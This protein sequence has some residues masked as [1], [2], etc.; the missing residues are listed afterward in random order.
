MTKKHKVH[1]LTDGTLITT[2]EL[3][4]KLNCSY[5]TAHHRLQRTLDPEELF[6]KIRTTKLKHP[7]KKYTLDDG[8]RRTVE[9]ILK[10]MGE[11]K[12]KSPTIIARLGI[13]RDPVDILKPIGKPGQRLRDLTEKQIHKF[14]ERD[15]MI[16]DLHGHWKLLAKIGVIKHEA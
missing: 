13:S 15:N 9:E 11:S 10:T 7:G 4:K 14:S 2:H 1:K 3:M 8:T 6:K 5:S 16:N 12:S